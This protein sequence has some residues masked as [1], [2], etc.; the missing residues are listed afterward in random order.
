M[1]TI[2]ATLAAVAAVTAVAAPAAAQPYRDQDRYEQ[3]RYDHDRHEQG[4]YEQDRRGPDH[5]RTSERVERAA[6]RIEQGLRNRELTPRE[7][8]GLRSELRDFARLED[9]F[10]R[11]GLTGRERTAL[12]RR[13]DRL[14]VAIKHEINDRDYGQGYGYGYRR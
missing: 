12:N 9:A 13:Y 6:S 7:A 3:G 2:L 14:I 10:R 11:D 8:A 4:R 1:K 5:W